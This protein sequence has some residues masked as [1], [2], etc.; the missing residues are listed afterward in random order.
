MADPTA[1]GALRSVVAYLRVTDGVV[2]EGWGP[3]RGGPY[4]AACTISTVTAR[5]LT[6][7]L[8]GL[9]NAQVPWA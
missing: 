6:G 1:R 4:R 2:R 7:S 8:T 3:G 5:L 9:G